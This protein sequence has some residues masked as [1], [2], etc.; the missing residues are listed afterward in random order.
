MEKNIDLSSLFDKFD[1]NGTKSLDQKE[2]AEMIYFL[3]PKYRVDQIAVLHE[4]LDI[5]GDGFI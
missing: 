5:R 3:A 2:F 1:E 4:I